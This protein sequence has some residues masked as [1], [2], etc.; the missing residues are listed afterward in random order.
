MSVHYALVP[1]HLANRIDFKFIILESFIS[2]Y[3]MKVSDI[4]HA[5]YLYFLYSTQNYNT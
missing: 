3:L 2:K 1:E 5:V 4:R